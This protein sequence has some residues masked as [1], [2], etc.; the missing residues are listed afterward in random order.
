MG[1]KIGGAGWEFSGVYLT[2]GCYSYKEG[3]YTGMVFYGTG[4]T[5]QQNK[6]RTSLPEYRPEGY[7][8]STKGKL[9]INST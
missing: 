2:K 7:D 4:G 8:C 3:P 1:L 9:H 5:K 6:A